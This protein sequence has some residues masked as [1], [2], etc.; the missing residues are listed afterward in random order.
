M[1]LFQ[2][3]KDNPAPCT[4]PAITPASITVT[5]IAMATL[6]VLSTVRTGGP[7]PARAYPNG[8]RT[9]PGGQRQP[10]IAKLPACLVGMA[11]PP[12]RLM[13]IPGRSAAAL[14]LL[15]GPSRGRHR[16]SRGTEAGIWPAAIT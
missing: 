8:S 7:W 14:M 10:L 13:A 1:W 16:R 5:L 15:T 2:D 3:S 4:Q 11:L 12:G 6:A 9:S